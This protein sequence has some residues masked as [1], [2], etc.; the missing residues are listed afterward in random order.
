M[1]S[2]YRPIIDSIMNTVEAIL[3]SVHV[4]VMLYI[5]RPL[6]YALV[7]RIP[8]YSIL[9]IGIIILIIINL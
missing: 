1:T 4:A 5:I 8:R 2:F 9:A 3:Y 7:W 6:F